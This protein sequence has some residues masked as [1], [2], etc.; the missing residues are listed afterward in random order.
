MEIHPF[1][2]SGLIMRVEGEIEITCHPY[3]LP[4]APVSSSL[5]SLAQAL[6]LME[7][8]DADDAPHV[9]SLLQECIM[10]SEEA[11]ATASSDPTMMEEIK[12]VQS[13]ACMLLAKIR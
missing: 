8:E 2:S 3:C 5:H 7:E 11:A 12:R 10:K 6:A 9:I 1:V 13:F 4:S